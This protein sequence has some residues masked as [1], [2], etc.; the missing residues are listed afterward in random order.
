MIGCQGWGKK[1]GFAGISLCYVCF[2]LLNVPVA[3]F[4]LCERLLSPVL[5][6]FPFICQRF[7]FLIPWFLLA[8]QTPISCC[9]L[10]CT[11]IP[12]LSSSFSVALRAIGFFDTHTFMTACMGL[13]AFGFVF[14]AHA[15]RSCLH[16]WKVH[17]MTIMMMM[18]VINELCQD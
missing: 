14:S 7:Q 15:R 16:G 3:W 18:V 13:W 5:A 9:P 1:G 6:M 17:A 12:S 8:C 4:L 11:L 10:L 2:H